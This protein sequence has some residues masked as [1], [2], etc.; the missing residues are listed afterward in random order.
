[1]GHDLSSIWIVE[2]C[3]SDD[4]DVCLLVSSL[5][6]TVRPMVSATKVEIATVTRRLAAMAGRRG[7]RKRRVGNSRRRRASGR[8]VSGMGSRRWQVERT[9][10]PRYEQTRQ[11]YEAGGEKSSR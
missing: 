8:L 9:G 10:L 11:L 6:R 1:M 3:F 5:A 4:V 2:G 7:R